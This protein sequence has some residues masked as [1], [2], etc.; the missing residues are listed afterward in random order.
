MKPYLDDKEFLIVTEELAKF[1]KNEITGGTLVFNVALRIR[2]KVK[3][4][5]QLEQ[6]KG[7]E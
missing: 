7:G 4:E 3:A 5:M 6:E 2:E 1:Y